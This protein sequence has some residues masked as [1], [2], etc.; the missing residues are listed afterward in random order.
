MSATPV[1]TTPRPAVAAKSPTPVEGNPF[2]DTELSNMRMV[3]A[4]RLLESKTTIP[5]YYLTISVTMDK[6]L[7]YILT[8]N[9]DFVRN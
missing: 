5:H 2:A 9:I 6:L 1:A 8:I 7:K 4:S 3:I